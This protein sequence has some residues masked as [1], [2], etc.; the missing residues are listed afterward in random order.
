M[1][2]L[3]KMR[4]LKR[5]SI[6]S[7]DKDILRFMYGA[8]RPVSGSQIAKR[9]SISSPTIRPHLNKLQLKGIVKPFHIGKVRRINKTVK[10]PSK[11]LW[12]L[13]LKKRKK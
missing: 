3:I 12:G 6:D 10:A 7:I 13:D 5:K 11:I 4:K 2:L 1:G 9:I 8:K